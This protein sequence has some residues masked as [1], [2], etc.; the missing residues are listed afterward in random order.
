[1]FL[2]SHLPMI[3]FSEKEFEQ[4][5]NRVT[6]KNERMEKMTGFCF[7]LVVVISVK[8]TGG[9]SLYLEPS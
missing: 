3:C 7:F 9:Y 5:A 8:V 4:D 1:M 6:G 2:S